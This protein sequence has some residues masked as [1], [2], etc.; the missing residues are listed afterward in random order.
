[1][2]TNYT[3]TDNFSLNLYGD[4]DPADLRD[5][6]NGSMRTID[7]T[8]EKHLNRIETLEA[9]DTH[10]AEVLKALGADSVDNATTA[11]TKWD[12]AATDATTAITDATTNNGLL[13]ALGADTTDH[14]TTAKTKWDQA[15][16]DATTN[17]GLL[18]ALGADSVDNATTV[19]KQIA[20]ASKIATRVDAHLNVTNKTL[21]LIL[22]N[23]FITHDFGVQSTVRNG[24]F[25]YYGC[26]DLNS[27]NLNQLLITVNIANNT[28]T[29]KQTTNLGH[30]ND[31]A[32]M[33]DWT[34]NNP[35]WIAGMVADD[36]ATDLQ[37]IRAYDPNGGTITTVNVPLS[38]IAGITR[39]PI[40]KRVFAVCRNKSDIYEIKQDGSSY[41]ATKIGDS[42]TGADFERQGIAAYN[43]VIFGTT[44][45]LFAW[46]F[47]V[48]TQAV[49]WHTLLG[50]DTE[51][52]RRIGEYEAGE[53]TS[54]GNL[55]YC[56]RSIANDDATSMM[57]W[58]G[59]LAS[60]SQ[61]VPRTIGG[62]TAKTAQTVEL[63]DDSLKPNFTTVN[64]CVSLFEI[65]TFVN[66]PMC[67][68][69][70][71]T[72]D[73]SAHGP[74][75]FSGLLQV[76]GNLTINKLMPTGTGGLRVP[77]EGV[78][79][80]TNSGTQIECSDRCSNFTY[81]VTSSLGPNSK[82][83]FRNG[84]CALSILACGNSDGIAL[85]DSVTETT[86]NHLYFGTTKII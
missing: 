31:M 78:V 61:A 37:G 45:R 58:G 25:A 20:D 10:D 82:V 28:I 2:A 46:S 74:L 65:P 75:R 29:T 54:D 67:V 11:K 66:P 9:T 7:D 71:T 19:K 41:T 16:T 1:M 72:L 14:A 68:K 30:I 33:G 22:Q 44:T 26:D 76:G 51:V 18:N 77:A 42:P 57:N 52:S 81:M 70:S 4:N 35:L 34:P 17:K 83:Q 59:W 32:W 73:D 21:S 53:F 62:H 39:D 60:A 80:I 27:G 50:T 8:L 47:D 48:T 40:T 63:V 24:D 38:A 55:W 86:A 15:A 13:A 69:V 3:K 64:Q 85:S 5:G 36:G 43:N 84:G 79:K 12:Q 56:A 23:H 49:Y 6:Y